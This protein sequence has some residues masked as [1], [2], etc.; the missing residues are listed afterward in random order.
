MGFK[1]PLVRIQSLGPIRDEESPGALSLGAFLII[2]HSPKFVVKNCETNC[3][4]AHTLLTQKWC[5]IFGIK[6]H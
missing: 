2:F 6:G 5:E 3:A 4:I 1:R